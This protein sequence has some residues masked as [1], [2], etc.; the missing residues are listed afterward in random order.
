MNSFTDPQMQLPTL[1]KIPSSENTFEDEML[2]DNTQ[3]EFVGPDYEFDQFDTEL[4]ENIDGLD[5]ETPAPADELVEE[6]YEN[7]LGT[8]ASQQMTVQ[9]ALDRE[10]KDISRLGIIQVAG[11]DRLGRKVIVF[12]ACRLP[13]HGGVDLQRLYEYIKKTLE[14]YVV[15]DYSLVYLHYG[16][17]S[18]NRPP[19]KWLIQAYRGFDRNF[20]KNLKALYLVHPTNFVL[21]TLKI[22][23]PIISKK[24]G[25]KINYI[26]R[27]GELS[28]D[29]FLDQLPIPQRVRLYD[30]QLLRN[31][32]PLATSLN[33]YS[34]F[35][36]SR[37][38][39]TKPGLVYTDGAKPTSYLPHQ[40]FGAS[41]EHIKSNNGGNP[42]PQ[43][44]EDCVMYI[45]QY[46][47]DLEGLFRRSA[48]SI[49]V[50]AAQQTYNE[51]GRV[52][53]ENFDDP[54]LPAVLIKT[55]FRELSEP[56][57]TYELYDEVLRV[58]NFTPTMK[59]E[60]A[61][62]MISGRLP[63]DNYRLLKYLMEFLQEVSAHAA[64][65]KMTDYNLGIVF[66]PN[67]LWSK[68]ANVD[69]F[70]AVGQITTFIQL[71]ISNFDDIF[72]K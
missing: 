11:D 6:D 55:F 49:L 48:R 34:A 21:V 3:S 14:Q 68:F 15:M 16:F 44:L 60:S 1:P 58:N 41:I 24:F 54:H 28:R 2:T 33:P 22:F 69:S 72:V 13:V 59:I 38:G 18:Q 56:I 42:I 30:A 63:A 61:R 20:K 25:Q 27:L 26:N 46:S 5:V 62:G 37:S 35:L 39:E 64:S 67:L 71:L 45:R 47:L 9:E 53:F 65:N 51:G 12:S 23:Q 4:A 10:Y 40:V 29:M 52:K 36:V 43:V 31:D 32:N 7:E 19:M 17:S 70:A 8:C 57:L 50:Q 66:G